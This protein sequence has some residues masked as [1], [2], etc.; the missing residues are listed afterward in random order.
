MNVVDSYLDPIYLHRW[1][2]SYSALMFYKACLSKRS[3]MKDLQ[4]RTLE[5]LFPF[6]EELYAIRPH[7]SFQVHLAQ[8]LKMGLAFD[9]LAH[10]ALSEGWSLEYLSCSNIS[11]N[12]Y[13]LI[14]QYAQLYAK[15]QH[16]DAH[17]D[18]SVAEC[19][20]LQAP[21]S[22]KVTEQTRYIMVPITPVPIAPENAQPLPKAEFALF[23]S[24]ADG[25]FSLQDQ[26][27][28]LYL[29]PHI[30]RAAQAW[31]QHLTQKHPISLTISP[32]CTEIQT[33]GKGSPD[34]PIAMIQRLGLTYRQAE[35]MLLV[36]QG[37][38]NDW[39]SGNL[40]CSVKT[41]KKHLENIYVRL[42]VATRAA[43]VSTAT[44]R[45]GF[46]QFDE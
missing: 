14:E 19:L 8:S 25:F 30:W 34:H 4:P 7:V 28:M 44:S 42:G 38:D 17:E 24:K 35:V 32:R 40:G 13:Q 33:D 46:L 41:V 6:L 15:A 23:F 39:I 37:K 29:R 22:C 36:I 26:L 10:V 31:K 9:G 20:L 16:F 43:A 1:K 27:F 2:G 18:D 45:A 11:Q 12:Q 21:E 5:I 3:G